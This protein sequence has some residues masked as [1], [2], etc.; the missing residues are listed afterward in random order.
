MNIGSAETIALIRE[1]CAIIASIRV[2]RP[3]YVQFKRLAEL[4]TALSGVHP[5]EI[6]LSEIDKLSGKENDV[7]IKLDASYRAGFKK[8][9]AYGMVS[10]VRWVL[11]RLA[12]DRST[13]IYPGDNSAKLAREIDRLLELERVSGSGEAAAEDPGGSLN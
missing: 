11:A 4:D 12:G 3:N 1:K 13:L 6:L 9:E 8:G 7:E 10:A 5:V 2:N